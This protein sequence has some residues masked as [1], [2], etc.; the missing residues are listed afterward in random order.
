MLTS[1]RTNLV[2]V[3]FFLELFWITLLGVILDDV[4]LIELH[5][6]KCGSK[7]ILQ[8]VSWYTAESNVQLFN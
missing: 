5:T 4:V 2:K 7:S 8:M 3:L 6:L 1:V